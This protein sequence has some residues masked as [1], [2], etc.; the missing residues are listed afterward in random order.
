MRTRHE[1]LAIPAEQGNGRV[2]RGRLACGADDGHV[3]A[4]PPE[5]FNQFGIPARLKPNREFRVALL[6][7]AHRA[8]QHESRL[9]VRGGDDQFTIAVPAQVGCQ[10]A[11]VGRLGKDVACTRNHLRPRCGYGI[12]TFAPAQEHLETELVLKLAQLS[13]NTRLGGVHALRRHRDVQAGIGNGDDVAQLG[14]CH[15]LQSAALDI[16]KHLPAQGN[17]ACVPRGTLARPTSTRSR[18]Q[19]GSGHRWLV[20]QHTGSTSARPVWTSK[21]L[22]GQITEMHK[23]RIAGY[24]PGKPRAFMLA[25]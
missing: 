8:R 3:G 4:A 13:G 19:D 18:E 24:F 14:Q 12:Q 11:N 6:H 23:P 20:R 25:A 2:G 21:R 17:R 9:G 10:G 5:Q 15:V 7:R 16:G 22:F 1:N